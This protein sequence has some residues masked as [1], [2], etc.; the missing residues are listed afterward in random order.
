VSGFAR[1]K[2]VEHIMPPW[3]YSAYP[4]ERQW[5]DFEIRRTSF[6]ACWRSEDE[7]LL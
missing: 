6:R 7:I 1:G 3:T 4:S 5:M 2:I